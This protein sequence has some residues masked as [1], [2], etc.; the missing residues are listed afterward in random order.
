VTPPANSNPYDIPTGPDG[1]LW[2]TEE[3]GNK[4]GRISP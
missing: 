1:L 3:G 4:I 2:F